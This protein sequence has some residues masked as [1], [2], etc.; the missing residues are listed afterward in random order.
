[1]NTFADLNSRIQLTAESAARFR[2][3]R[4]DS[5]GLVVGNPPW[6]GVLKGPLSPVYDD[7]KK[8]HLRMNY[9][10]AATGKFD[11][12]GV[13]LEL[14]HKLNA[15]SGRVAMITQDTF[16]EKDWATKLRRFLSS[17]A[18]IRAIID[19]NPFGQ[20]FFSAMNTPAITVFDS[21]P[22]RRGSFQAVTTRAPKFAEVAV[23]QRRERVLDAVSAALERLGNGQ[24]AATFDCA[25]AWKT[26][27]EQLSVQAES[28][29]TLRP[30]KARRTR[31]QGGLV[32]AVDLFEPRQ[33]VTPGMLD[34]FLITADTI[35]QHSIEEE[36]CHPAI[37]T[38]EMMKWVVTRGDRYLLYPY[39]VEIDRNV[40]AFADNST[41]NGDAL[42][43]DVILDDIERRI[44][45][46]RPLDDKVAQELV[47]HRIAVGLVRYPHA[48][49]YLSTQFSRLDGRIFKKRTMREFG[50]RW[51]EY[52]W[53]R[54]ARLITEKERILSPRLAREPRF[55]LD[56]EGT[57]S[58]D[59]CLLLLPK[60][61]SQWIGL[62]TSLGGYLEREITT[63]D[64]L[65]YSLAF[66]NSTYALERLKRRKP[67]PKGS[68]AIGEKYIGE[69]RIAFPT[70][71]DQAQRVFSLVDQCIAGERGA[72]VALASIVDELLR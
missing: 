63:A 13:F 72:A 42:D 55:S 68:Y 10:N 36:L 25:S 45:R 49:R 41:R 40:P 23:G 24:R 20:L 8:Q 19:L 57:L 34:V 3:M 21:H 39:R 52:I 18:E 50:R 67:T 62:A 58:D 9:P 27:R 26:S 43:F 7:V 2:R 15:P 47:E 71:S 12:D 59:A 22:P 14:A 64:V 33:G 61:T 4:E 28:G 70:G 56:V 1:V 65:R 48:A 54:D 17:K 69:L 31:T 51:Y 53:P 32:A 35:R 44:R 38:R 46:G 60:K 37:K 6:G 5:Y 11:V 30:E 66:L 16:L 29:W